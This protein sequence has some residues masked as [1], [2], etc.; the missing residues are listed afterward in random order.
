MLADNIIIKNN[1]NYSIYPEKFIGH[2]VST[3]GL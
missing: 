1:S 3:R 2:D